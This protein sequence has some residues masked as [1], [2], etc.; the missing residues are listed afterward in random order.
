MKANIFDEDR[1]IYLF[2]SEQDGY[3]IEINDYLFNSKHLMNLH[4][5]AD[6]TMELP[7]VK[8]FFYFI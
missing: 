8:Y 6:Y 3:M 5:T 4:L 2:V 7:D 1:D